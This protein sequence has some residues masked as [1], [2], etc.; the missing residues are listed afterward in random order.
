MH[1]ENQ[2]AVRYERDGDVVVLV[3]DDPGRSANTMNPR[4]SAALDEALD[5]LEAE[6]DELRGVLLTS[7][8]K[9]FFAG[10]DLDGMGGTPSAADLHHASM[11][12]KRQLR[13]LETL[14]V[15]VVACINGAALGGGL[16]LALACHHRIAADVPGCVIGLPEVQLGLLPGAGGV[17][18]TVRM[19]GLMTA[20]SEVLSTGRRFRPQAAREAGLVDE[21]VDSADALV[22]AALAWLNG[23]P[24]SV[25]PW[26]EPGY[27][28][29]G[30]DHT[31]KSLAPLLG[32]MPGMVRKQLK[33]AP[34]PAPVAILAAAVEGIQVDFDTASEIE[35][36]H[37]VS[38]VLGKVSHNMTKAFFH[39]MQA[40]NGG[41]QRPD[42]YPTWTPTK[43]GVLGAGMMG[44]GIAYVV[45]KA[46]VEVVL[47]DVSDEAAEKGK[48]YSR[49][50]VDKAVER[51]RCSREDADALLD[52][53]RATGDPAALAGC[54]AVV[55]AVFEKVELKHQVLAEAEVV[56]APDALLASNTSTLPITGL[57]AG[58]QRSTDFI[59]LHFFSP[60]DKMPLVEI[61]RGEETS[62]ETLARAFDVV[63]LIGKTPI[64]V[65]DSRGFFTSRVIGAFMNEGLHLLAEGLH[66]A[67]VE[68]ASAQA[69]Y[70]A[71]VLQL[72]DEL[73]LRLTHEIGKETNA[74]LAAEGKPVPEPTAAERVI[75][76]M[77]ETHDRGGRAL[78]AG[79]YEYADGRR[80]RLWPGLLEEFGGRPDAVPF[81]EAQERLLFAETI[82]AMRCF[83]EGVITS[84]ADANVGS[85]LGIGFPAWTG[86]VVQYVEQ[87]DGGVAGFVAR[88]DEYADRLGERFRPPQYLRDRA[89]AAASPAA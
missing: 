19:L 32:V 43:V 63:R 8:K 55:E 80:Q 68:Q 86:G 24:R 61:I 56:A 29:P 65:N 36:R 85:I 10:A 82:E 69:G 57:A 70:P 28:I 18:R 6:R 7:A 50:L 74:Q 39:D 72:F 44:A 9:T 64:V 33:G 17:V 46:G 40:V 66:P 49:R 13:R 54:D 42:G 59:G 12:A 38:L 83:D 31:S 45:A 14:G 79:F 23:E 20:F 71:P 75:T 4:F 11:A 84:D 34:M 21:V 15:P 78:G 76:T 81:E 5:R 67:S 53:I 35:A 3:M 52:R 60:V 2:T 16:E 27:R 58:V 25:Q 37:F 41:Q 48:D 89:A 77:V 62:D 47:K 1:T 88:A 51:G 73:S 30:G 26:D 22:P 87:Y